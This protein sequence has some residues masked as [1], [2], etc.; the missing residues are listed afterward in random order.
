MKNIGRRDFLKMVAAVPVG[1]MLSHFLPRLVSTEPAS[2]N[3]IVVV[4]DA[5]SARNMSLYGYQRW[6]TPNIERFATRCD[7]YHTHHSAG[8]FTTSGTASLLTGTYPWT[9]RAINLNGLIARDRYQ[10]N[11]FRLFESRYHRIAFTQN[12]FA[13]FLLDQFN[14]DID[15]HLPLGSF[16][17]LN[18][19][20]TNIREKDYP[21]KYEAFDN[22]LFARDLNDTPGSLVLGTL[23]AYLKERTYQKSQKAGLQYSRNRLI[24]DIDQVFSGLASLVADLETSSFCYFHLFPPHEPYS[25]KD[26]FRDLFQ[27]GW[28]PT[29]KPKHPLQSNISQERLDSERLAYDQYIATTDAAFGQFL[30]EIER[31][32]LRDNSYLILTSDHG[33]SFERGYWGH[34]GPLAYEPGVHI[35]LLISAP[36]QKSRRD[37]YS[38]TNSVDLLPSL[39][40][41]SGLPIPAWCEGKILPGNGGQADEARVAFS[42]DAKGSSA[43]DDLSPITLA[44]HQGNYKLIYYKGYGGEGYPYHDGVFELYNLKNDPEELQDLVK[45]E[46]SVAQHM[47]GLLLDA[48]NKAN[49]LMK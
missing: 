42:M 39:L 3:I 44:M 30:D 34:A 19:Y 17:Q 21:P 12:A 36:G 15:E 2:P 7:V 5:L 46:V 48:Y 23:N 4:L 22:F 8:T 6:T 47:Q 31:T 18:H 32:G 1:M 16:S 35:P 25:P 29:P 41:I 10:R 11:S 49:Q 45:D 26:D 40:K 28:Q 43:F 38:L 13:N 14:Q 33:E 20:L 24:F 9:H 37:F 27:N